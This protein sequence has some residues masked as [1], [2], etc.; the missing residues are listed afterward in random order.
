MSQRQAVEKKK[1]KG[2]TDGYLSSTVIQFG[3]YDTT[4]MRLLLKQYFDLVM[5]EK[6]CF[7]FSR[8]KE[9]RAAN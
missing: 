7:G 5:M 1:K 9:K 3:L 6:K 4:I 2:R 8:N